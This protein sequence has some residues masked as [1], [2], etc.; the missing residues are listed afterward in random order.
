M[1]YNSWNREKIPPRISKEIEDLNKS[2][3]SM[4]IDD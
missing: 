1:Y 3:T 2:K 4:K